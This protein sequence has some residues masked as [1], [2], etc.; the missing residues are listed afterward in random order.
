MERLSFVLLAGLLAAF[1]LILVP[2]EGT[3][4]ESVEPITDII[5]IVAVIFFSLFLVYKGMKAIFEK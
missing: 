2:L 4:L 3:F 5:G 1:A